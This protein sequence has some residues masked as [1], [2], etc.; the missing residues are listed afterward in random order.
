MRRTT[1]K[2]DV[3]QEQL[4]QKTADTAAAGSAFFAGAAW[5][6]DVEPYLTAGAAA[7]AIVAG[8]AAAWYHLERAAALR[9]SRKDAETERQSRRADAANKST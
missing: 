5:I 2:A 6:A 3:M 9:A 8:I 4:T 1:S 7:V